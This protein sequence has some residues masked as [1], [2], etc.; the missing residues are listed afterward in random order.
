MA[1]SSQD[2]KN[3]KGKGIPHYASIAPRL[4]A[5]DKAAVG[6]FASYTNPGGWI[7][8]KLLGGL[9]P[10]VLDRLGKMAVAAADTNAHYV[11]VPL[12]NDKT[13]GHLGPD[14]IAKINAL[15]AELQAQRP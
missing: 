10:A 14:L 1:Y 7:N 11:A 2:F 8:D 15:Q 9:G 3:D 5:L 4:Q 12:T 13:F 6:G